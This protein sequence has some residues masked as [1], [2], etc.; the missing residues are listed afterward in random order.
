MMPIIE[1]GGRHK[2]ISTLLRPGSFINIEGKEQSS[3][4]STVTKIS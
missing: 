3:A 2:P 1:V 4:V